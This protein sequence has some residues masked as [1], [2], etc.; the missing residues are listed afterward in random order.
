MLAA[1]YDNCLTVCLSAACE[2]ASTG[3]T[4]YGKCLRAPIEGDNTLELD[5][6][7]RCF[8]R[9][10]DDGGCS[11]CEDKGDEC[12]DCTICEEAAGWDPPSS[13]WDDDGTATGS[14]FDAGFCKVLPCADSITRSYSAIQ[15]SIQQ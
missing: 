4:A 7:D 11:D 1:D 10:A 15:S 8:D 2:G 6:N 13:E 14:L 9:D 5:D 3:G 12:L